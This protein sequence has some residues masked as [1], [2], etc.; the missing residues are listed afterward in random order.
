MQRKLQKK[1]KPVAIQIP[2]E[3]KKTQGV[4]PKEEK[5]GT[6]GLDDLDLETFILSHPSLLVFFTFQFLF[7]SIE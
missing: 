4:T 6:V 7:I 1:K 2:K 3:E 5:L